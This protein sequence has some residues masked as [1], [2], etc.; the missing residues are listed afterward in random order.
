MLGMTK[1]IALAVLWFV[2][3]WTTTAM[4]SFVLAIPSLAPVVAVAAAGLALSPTVRA[5]ALASARHRRDVLTPRN[6]RAS[7]Q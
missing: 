6:S 3:A 5:R 7:L 4:V 2:A 1:R